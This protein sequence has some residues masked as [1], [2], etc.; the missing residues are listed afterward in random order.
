MANNLNLFFYHLFFSGTNPPLAVES[1]SRKIQNSRN[2]DELDTGCETTS[3]LAVELSTLC[4][5]LMNKLLT[6]L[7]A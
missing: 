5:L 6:P 1:G 7:T 4:T 3:S 2:P